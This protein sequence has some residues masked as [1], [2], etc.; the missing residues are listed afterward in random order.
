MDYL[1]IYNKLIQHA[2]EHA[3]ERRALNKQSIYFEGHHIIPR[4]LNGTGSSKEWKYSNYNVNESNIV[5]LT[6]KEHYIAHLLLT[7]IY[8]DNSQI[9]YAFLAMV[10]WGRHSGSVN[11]SY[12][13]SAKQYQSIKE[14]RKKHSYIQ[15]RSNYSHSN[16]TKQKISESKKGNTWNKGRIVSDST[17]ELISKANS[18]KVRS[19]EFKLQIS[20]LHKG[21]ELSEETKQK[22]SVNG[23]GRRYTQTKVVC[24]HCKKEGGKAN[25]TRH[26]FDNCNYKP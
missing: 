24:P 8:P 26:H 19:D 10:Q 20:I 13:I 17:K 5:P 18:G 3:E 21:K 16:E 23:K 25:M 15:T 9:F 1:N 22:I 7:K 12:R 14:L 6:A 4:C 2:K 11:R